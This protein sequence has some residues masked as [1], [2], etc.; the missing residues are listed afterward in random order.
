MKYCVSFCIVALALLCACQPATEPTA[1]SSPPAAP[2][3]T[4][5]DAQ[6]AVDAYAAA[7]NSG[8]VETLVSMF[9]D[10][11]MI[12]PADAPAVVGR[13]AIRSHLTASSQNPSKLSVKVEEVLGGG[14]I[15]CSRGVFTSTGTPADA[16]E[17]IT[18]TGKWISISKIHAD[19]SRM[20]YRH[21]WNTDEPM[22]RPTT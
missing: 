12:L 7:A 10:D 21:I 5:G 17:P 8:D 20:I 2:A 11:A 9:A 19:G 3:I 4:I 13:A 22:P 18:I 14:D 1:E 15:S 6:T 16:E